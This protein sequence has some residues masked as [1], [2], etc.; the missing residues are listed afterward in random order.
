MSLL[1]QGHGNYKA[2]ASNNKTGLAKPV[3][4]VAFSPGCKRLAAAGDA[5]IIALYDMEHG[6]HVGNLS[7]SSSGGSSSNA[8][9]TSIDWNHNG[10][11][12][13]SG[14]LDGKVRVWD[15]DRGVCVATHSETDKALWSVRWLPKT[16][17]ALAPGMGKGEMFCAAGANRSITFY[18][19]ATGM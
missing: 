17:K 2:L 12:L 1:W 4:A 19:E 15:V 8:W 3:R 18:R 11:Y 5:G 6:E 16:D 13:L 14:S 7:P 10:E 9:I